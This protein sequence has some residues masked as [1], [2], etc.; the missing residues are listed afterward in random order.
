MLNLYIDFKSPTSY[1]A[2]K[3]TL[4]FIERTGTK[5]NWHPFA[6]LERDL[7]EQTSTESV[8]ES[9]RRVRAEQRRA[10]HVKYAALQG[11]ELRFPHPRGTTDLALGALATLEGDRLPFIKAA[12]EAYWIA[13]ANLDDAATVAALLSHNGY[14]AANFDEHALRMLQTTAQKEAET[15]GIVEAPAYIIADQLFIGREHL[16]WIEEIING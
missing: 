8:G 12:F 14:D 10:T 5:A 16:P 6:T 13:H 4:G 7:P 3:P 9:H 15:L 2:I 11:I 1:L